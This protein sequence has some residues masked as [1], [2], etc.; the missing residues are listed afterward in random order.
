VNRQTG[1]LAHTR[2]VTLV[3]DAALVNLGFVS[4]VRTDTGLLWAHRA[5]RPTW[6]SA[7]NQNIL[8]LPFTSKTLMLRSVSLK[9]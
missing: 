1:G 5:A 7:Q 4:I 8:C 9:T 3:I 2:T 6:S